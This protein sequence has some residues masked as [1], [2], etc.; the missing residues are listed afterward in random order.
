VAKVIQYPEDKIIITDGL[1][2]ASEDAILQVIKNF[3]DVWHTVLLV[4]HNPG[5]SF[6]AQRLCSD[7]Q[8]N[9]D[10]GELR[11]ISFPLLHWSDILPGNGQLISYA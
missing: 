3:D 5:L 11:V 10:V 8:D 9:L 4:G 6:L 1:Y 2:N 7:V